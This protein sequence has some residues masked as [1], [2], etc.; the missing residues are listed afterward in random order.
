MKKYQVIYA[1]PP[2]GVKA[3]PPWASSGKSRDLVYPTMTIEQIKA[4]PV[5]ELAGKDSW[6]FLWTINK[7]ISESYEIARL[8]GF[9]PS[10]LLTWCKKP[11]GLGLGGTFVQTS[12]HL[13]FCRRGG[14]KARKRVDT[15]WFQ[16][17][18]RKHSEKP[19]EIRKI[20]ED[21]SPD[22]ATKLEMFARQKPDGWDIWGNE[23]PNDIELT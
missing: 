1:D 23:L 11:H 9:K 5:R 17:P 7:Y 8:W 21:I 18:R 12:E 4:L 22:G 2:W 15:S 13:L 10:C 6:L 20:I 3:G 14:L 16:Y 19:H